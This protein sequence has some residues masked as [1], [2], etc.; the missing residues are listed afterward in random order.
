MAEK[1]GK[2]EVKLLLECLEILVLIY[3]SL[4]KFRK[5]NTAAG[6]HTAQWKHDI[7]KEIV[8]FK[9]RYL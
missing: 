4:Y 2:V 9:L 5:H 6:H 1:I 8:S 7:S 3:F